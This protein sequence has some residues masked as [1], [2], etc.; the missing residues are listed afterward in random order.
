MRTAL[1]GHPIELLG[2]ASSMLTMF[3]VRENGPFRAPRGIDRANV[4]ESFIDTRIPETTGLLTSLAALC[5]DD[6]MAAQIR[7]ELAQRRHPQ[8]TWLANLGLAT[9]TARA[10]VMLDPLGDG[11]NIVFGVDLPGGDS[12][13]AVVYVEHNLGSLVKDAFVLPGTLA[14]VLAQMRQLNAEPDLV[15]ADLDSA[16]ARVRITEAIEIAAMT[17]PPFESETWPAA[18]RLVEWMTALLPAGGRGYEQP[19]WSEKQTLELTKRFLASS[20]AEG[21]GKAGHREALDH[22]LWFGTDH[23]PGDP[24]RWSPIAVELLLLDWIPR[25][26]IDTTE[27]LAVVPEVLRAFV[28]FCHAERGLRP[29]LTADVL[30]TIDLYEPEYQRLVASSRSAGPAR[31]LSPLGLMDL[32]DDLDFYDDNAW[33]IDWDN[34]GDDELAELMIG[35]LERLV[36]GKL[37]LAKLDDHPLPA[38]EFAWD[39][40]PGDIHDR[41][42]EVLTLTDTCCSDLLDEEYRTVTRRVL[43]DAAAKDPAIFRRAGRAETAAAAICWLAGTANSLFDGTSTT[44]K[45]RYAKDLYAYFGL[46][47]S[48]SASQ[49]A[50][51]I[52]RALRPEVPGSYGTRELVRTRYLISERRRR[53]IELRERYREM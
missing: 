49:R 45:L 25:K 50:Q 20:F 27:H 3:D 6:V 38:E 13:T 21:L 23:A 4:L 28:R 8:P 37:A 35:H 30:A 44:P 34:L 9:P 29:G 36:G 7:R 39:D 11:D 5:G 32:D 12:L 18:R 40:V 24:L 46:K 52:L 48:F 2:L 41:V 47:P 19:G 42:R 26:I 15:F 1:R 43:A 22:I 17:V 33:D 31:S 16:D 14:E 51:P 53:I 10:V